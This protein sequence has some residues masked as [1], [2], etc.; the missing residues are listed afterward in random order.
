MPTVERPAALAA[1]YSATKKKIDDLPTVMLQGGMTL[2]RYFNPN[3]AYSLLPKPAPGGHVSKSQA[4]KL[5]FPGDGRIE[6]KN[7]FRGP[8]YDPRI[9]SAAGLYCVLQQQALVNE[10]AHFPGYPAQRPHL[11]WS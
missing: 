10:S 4:N 5:L 6:L 8:S 3:G 9:P 1:A 11:P 2:F 7:R